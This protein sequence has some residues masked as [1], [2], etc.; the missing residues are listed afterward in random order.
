MKERVFRSTLPSRAEAPLEGTWQM[1][2]GRAH[3]VDAGRYLL[4]FHRG[5]VVFRH[6]TPPRWGGPGRF[7]L[8]GNTLEI[9]FADGVD[10]VYRWNVYRGR[11][12]LRSTDKEVG[13]PNPTFGPL[14]SHQ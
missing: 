14:V 3:G 10:A 13:P 2:A 8:H 12:T 7:V 6:L 4:V 5:R 9:R 11:L 1:T